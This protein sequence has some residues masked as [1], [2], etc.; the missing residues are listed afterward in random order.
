MR[1]RP[2]SYCSCVTYNRGRSVRPLRSVTLYRRAR[3]TALAELARARSVRPKLARR[4]GRIPSGPAWSVTPKA[5]RRWPER[6]SLSRETLRPFLQSNSNRVKR[7]SASFYRP[8]VRSVRKK[9][10]RDLLIWP[11]RGTEA[12]LRPASDTG[13]SDSVS[14]T[15]ESNPTVALGAP[16]RDLVEGLAHENKPSEL[17]AEPP[18]ARSAAHGGVEHGRGVRR[19]SQGGCGA[20]GKPTRTRCEESSGCAPAHA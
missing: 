3:L 6:P 18:R 8:F 14:A 10:A 13:L 15:L 5:W 20:R 19:A 1:C 12:C 11:R 2:N 7:A 16:R 17:P 9:L 4:S